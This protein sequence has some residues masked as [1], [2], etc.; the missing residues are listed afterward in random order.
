MTSPSCASRSSCAP[1]SP[2]RPSCWRPGSP[3][4]AVHAASRRRP[5]A[6]AAVCVWQQQPRQLQGRT[7][8]SMRC[9]ADTVTTT[10]PHARVH[11]QEQRALDIQLCTAG[12]QNDHT[13]H[14]CGSGGREHAAATCWRRRISRG[15]GE[16]RTAVQRQE[17]P[18]HLIWRRERTTRCP[19]WTAAQPAWTWTGSSAA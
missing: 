10:S 12:A 9:T 3:A 17:S 16:E 5:F 11:S 1:R 7:H 2:L 8:P 18:A 14:S 15:K 4:D 19:K 6:R 13:V